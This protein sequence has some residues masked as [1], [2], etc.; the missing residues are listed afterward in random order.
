MTRAALASWAVKLTFSDTRTGICTVYTHRLAT[1]FK[2]V[3]SQSLLGELLLIES[4]KMK[5][6]NLEISC[7]GSGKHSAAGPSL[8]ASSS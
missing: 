7:L 5:I 4:E 8:T 2:P 3:V 1:I 6:S